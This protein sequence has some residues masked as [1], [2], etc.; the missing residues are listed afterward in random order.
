VRGS[1]LANF[2]ASLFSSIARAREVLRR[3]RP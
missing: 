3:W 2:G 1:D